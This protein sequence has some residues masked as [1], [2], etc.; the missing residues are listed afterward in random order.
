MKFVD[1]EVYDD[2]DNLI[3]TLPAIL[4]RS[5]NEIIAQVANGVTSVTFVGISSGQTN[6][7]AVINNK[8]IFVPTENDTYR[9]GS[10]TISKHNEATISGIR[11]FQNIKDDKIN[12]LTEAY[13]NA[14]T[15][16]TSNALGSTKTYPINQEARDKFEEYQ[17]RLIADPNKNS[18]YFLTIEDGI[19]MQHTRSQ[20]LQLLDDAESFEVTLHNKYRGLIN[21][22]NSAN[23][24]LTVNQVT[25]S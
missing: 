24:E 12:E 1:F 18:F 22:V 17:N 13:D 23:D 15:T 14:F 19:L 9:V 6:N 7:V 3:E 5:G 8:A 25:W 21:K 2:N 11:T 20:F 10:Q 16:F 4:Y